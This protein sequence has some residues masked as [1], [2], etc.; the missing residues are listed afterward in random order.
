MKGEITKRDYE[1]ADIESEVQRKD[2]TIRTLN[3]ELRKRSHNESLHLTSSM[4]DSIQQLDKE[5][6]RK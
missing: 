5:D 1:L 6:I 4:I 2:D 3:S